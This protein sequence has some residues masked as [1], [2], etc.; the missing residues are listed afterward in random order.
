[1][2]TLAAAVVT[3]VAG[4]P[5]VGA[6]T[7]SV[8]DSKRRSRVAFNTAN[9]VA[10]VTDYRFELK[11][12]ND[13]VKKTIA[14]TD[15]R[16]WADICR[17]ISVAGYRAVEIWVAHVDPSVMTDARAKLFRKILEDSNLEPIGLGASLNDDTARICQQLGIPTCNGGL[18]RNGLKSVQQLVQ[19]TGIQFNYEN[20]TEKSVEELKAKIAE[21][22]AHIGL[23]V[24]TGWLGTQGLDAPAT[25]RALGSSLVRHVHIKDVKQIGS[26]LTCPLGMGIVNIPGAI[27]A[28]REIG[29]TGWY[30]WEDEPED[31]NPME[32]ARAM[33]EHIEHLLG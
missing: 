23:A 5:V 26:H 1:M 33:R 13:Q 30:S 8:S 32:I 16:A 2:H 9:L 11:H 28:L 10:R 7:A 20:H 6:V 18:G 24:D 25:I 15:E 14:A 4:V 22:G 29:Y 27:Q 31:R 21:G 19:S 3:S 17:E 12:W